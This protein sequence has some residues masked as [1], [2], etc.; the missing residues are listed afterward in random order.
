MRRGRW[1]DDAGT[2]PALDRARQSLSRARRRALAY[3]FVDNCRIAGLACV[4]LLPG[5]D[6]SLVR[7]PLWT[8]SSTD[9]RIKCLPSAWPPKPREA[10]LFALALSSQPGRMISSLRAL[11][12]GFPDESSHP[13]EIARSGVRAAARSRRERCGMGTWKADR[14]GRFADCGSA[15]GWGSGFGPKHASAFGCWWARLLVAHT[16]VGSPRLDHP[17]I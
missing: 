1:L 17:G 7:K 3:K 4:Q 2:E 14:S 5:N 12:R 11:R 15:D 6:P 16:A 10:L 8:P 9:L 13:D